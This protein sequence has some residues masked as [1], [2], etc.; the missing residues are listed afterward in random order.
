M[1]KRFSDF[2]D[3]LVFD[4]DYK[5]YSKNIFDILDKH[6][7][8]QGKI[9]EIGCGTGNLTQELAKRPYNILAFDFSEEML[10]HA[11][12]KLIDFENVNLIKYDMYKFPYS[13]YEFDAIITLL[14]VINYI[15]DPTKLKK[16]FE[17]VYEGLREGGVFVFDLNSENKLFTVMGDNHYVYERGDI[18]YTWE[19]SR[20]EDLVHFDLNF[21]IKKDGLYE[22]VSEKQTERYYSISYIKDLL[23]E[24]G[25]TNITFQDEDGG[26]YSENTQRILFS[27]TK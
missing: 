11:F 10:N 26:E 24:V 21:F 6:N 9:L 27:V 8:D 3:E 14:D 19:N 1:Y 22:R 2:Y 15:T 7:I 4:I 18:F 16:L 23:S 17:G 25:F 5:L 20:E 12:P 13:S